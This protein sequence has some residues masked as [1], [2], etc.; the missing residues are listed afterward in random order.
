MIG[1]TI[2]SE[3]DGWLQ[4]SRPSSAMRHF[5]ETHRFSLDVFDYDMH[6]FEDLLDYMDFQEYEHYLFILQGE[7]E[8]TLRLV[9]YLQQQM[10]HVQFHLIRAE[11]DIVFG[12]PDFLNGLE[13]PLIF[14]DEKLVLPIVQNELLSLMTGVHRYA[15]L[16]QPQPLRHVYIEDSSL[17][18]RIP[19]SFFT[20]M[21]V[22]SIVY[23]DHPMRHDLSIIELMSR[24]PVLLAF[25]DTLSPPL[26]TRLDVL[27]RAELARQ[28]ERWKDT[29]WIQ[30]ERF[31]GILDYAT[32]TGLKNSHRLF[33]F[34]DGIY[35][36]RQKT[37]RL[38]SDISLMVEQRAGQL[39]AMATPKELEL[40]P[41]LYQL[42]GS[43]S[44][45]SRFVT[46]YSDLELPRTI[47]R[48]GPLTLIGIQNE[49]GYFAF[50]LT[51]MQ[52]F[53]TNEAF[54]WILEADQKEQ[55][56]VLP[57]RL[58]ADYAE[59]IRYYKELMYHE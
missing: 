33:F 53:E 13:L 23:F 51:S 4:R 1:I 29:G 7:G 57:E 11:G 34:E 19:A 3:Q 9:A 24:M 48:I 6:T 8:R 30:N 46:P 50:D 17:L 26:E 41:L 43:F 44:G 28:L 47:G 49:E 37:D 59:A 27:S 39:E 58:G 12:Q 35:A 36:D 25:G 52:L 20:S 2:V 55:F 54:L 5:C 56:D 10:L 38:S 16:F 40:F 31:A 45:E 22:N 18:N 15:S 21:T 14:E 42:A 32:Q